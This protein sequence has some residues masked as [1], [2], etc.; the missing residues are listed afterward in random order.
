V[1][2]EEL[3]KIALMVAKFFVALMLVL[4]GMYLLEVPAIE[5]FVQFLKHVLGIMLIYYGMDIDW[6]VK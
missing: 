3:L 2:K 5:D 4:M 1:Y 6:N